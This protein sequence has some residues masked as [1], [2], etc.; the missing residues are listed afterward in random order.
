M[1]LSISLVMACEEEHCPSVVMDIH[2]SGTA[3]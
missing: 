1:L 2:F 3:E